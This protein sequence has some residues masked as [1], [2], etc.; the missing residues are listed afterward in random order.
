MF[1]YGTDRPN[2]HPADSSGKVVRPAQEPGPPTYRSRMLRPAPAALLTAATAPALALTAAAIAATPAPASSAPLARPAISLDDRAAARRD[3]LVVRRVNQATRL[4]R[5]DPGCRQT[6]DFTSTFTDTAPSAELQASFA[7]LR[8][9]AIPEDVPTTGPLPW[10][11]LLGA[12]GIYRRWIRMG[13]AADGSEHYLVTAQSRVH[14]QPLSR[15]CLRTRHA[16][17]VRL[18]S[19]DD[20][21]VRRSALRTEQRVNRE[22]QPAA[23]FPRR[24]AIYLLARA[25]DGSIG[26]GGGGADLAWVRR[27]GSFS[28]SQYGDQERSHVVGL[29]PDGVA[30]IEATF[31]RRA[32]VP[33]H[34][35]PDLYPTEITHTL[36]V[37]DNLVSFDVEREAPDAF[38]SKM[39]WRAEDGS[40]VRT[41]RDRR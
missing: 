19:R 27:H 8:R 3:E 11:E 13:R 30:T 17:L 33:P 12:S 40:I 38:P 7:L 10:L 14:A 2:G 24:E 26:G 9:T 16:Q 34:T 25:R 35:A 39:V 28:T 21:R 29:L 37:Q 18:L 36:T 23:G 1:A 15:A 41:L 22:E 5:R 20:P 32:K 31:T 6:F 4:M